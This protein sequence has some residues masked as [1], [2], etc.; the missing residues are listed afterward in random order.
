MP[1]DAQIRNEVLRYVNGIVSLDGFRNWFVPRSLDVEE[2]QN[3]AAI[4]LAHRIDGILGESSA[5]NWSEDDIREELAKTI[6]PFVQETGSVEVIVV[7][8]ISG[9]QPETSNATRPLKL[10]A[11]AA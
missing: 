9:E 5:A 3:L 11:V 8:R 1:L 4:V 7:F 6:H 10:F 2:S